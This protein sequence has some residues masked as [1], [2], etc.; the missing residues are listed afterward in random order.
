MDFS[1]RYHQKEIMDDLESTGK[2]VDYALK[3]LDIINKWL[4]GNEITLRGLKM[5]R[6]AGKIN[7]LHIA[8]LGCGSGTMLKL[9]AD[10]G[11][12]TGLKLSL[13]GFD[14]N[15]YII[16][17]AREQTRD[18]PEVE[19]CVENV[20]DGSFASR[21]FDIITCTLFAHHLDDLQ[22]KK[23]LPSWRQQ[24][25]LGL[26]INDL[27]R[28]WLAYYSIKAITQVFSKS[29]M[30][31]HDAPVSVHRGFSRLDWDKIMHQCGFDRYQLSWHWA[32]RW[33][34]VIPGNP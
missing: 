21:S 30:V 23:M 25:K 15:P 22:L 28:H 11:R 9:I 2:D 32:F 34:L 27:H 18:Y 1:A 31:R 5:L 24:A 19:F 3:E 10:W 6:D 4:G 7:Q 16:D 33:L 26:V 13:T 20:L 17:F 14:A 8:D 12:K 29:K